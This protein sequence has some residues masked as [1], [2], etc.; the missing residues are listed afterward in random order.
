MPKVHKLKNNITLILD[1]NEDSLLTSVVVGVPVGSNNENANQ[2]GM[3]HFL[4]HMFFKGTKEYPNK[5]ALFSKT[6]SLGMY[7]NAGTS[8]DITRYYL[9][10]DA[11]HTEEMI[12][13]LSEMFINS[14]FEAQG[15]EKEKG[16][17]IEEI[18]R[19][20][21]MHKSRPSLRTM[22]S[23]LFKDTQAEHITLGTIDSVNSFNRDGCLEFYE[24]HYVAD[25]TIIVISGKFDED[26]VLKKVSEEFK[27]T[28]RG[29]ATKRPVLKINKT[30]GNQFSSTVNKDMKQTNVAI[31]FYSVGEDSKKTE[32]ATV[33]RCCVRWWYEFQIGT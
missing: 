6:E 19:R 31:F 7:M 17:V 32:I 14:L 33:I 4:E 1:S 5:F 8:S 10:G 3:A 2:R 22:A 28:R 29:E 27:N 30:L 15:L 26:V 13:I 12:H 25:N 18:K 20:N 11:K 16:V 23:D 24:K 21:V 9:F